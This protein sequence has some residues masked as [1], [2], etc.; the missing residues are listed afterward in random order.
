MKFLYPE[1]KI[2]ALTFS[3]DDAQKFDR[4]LVAIFNKYGMKATFHL[5]SGTL[6]SN[7]EDLFISKEEVNTLYAGHEI[8]CH[9]VEHKNLTLLTRQK[10]LREVEDDRRELER[11]TGKIVQGMSYAYGSYSADVED[12]I[13]TV[14]I[15]YSRTV[16]STG[17]FGVPANFLEWHP[18]CHHGADLT[19][20]GQRFLHTPDWEELPL[21]Y[22]WGH[23]FEFDREQNWD[24]LDKF[25]EL[26]AGKDDIWYATNM[27]ICDYINATRSLEY[28]M[29]GKVVHNP[30]AVTI[31]MTDGDKVI[32][33]AAGETMELA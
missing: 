7:M 5:N 15:K 14:G 18:T 21:L 12:V 28:S 19:E 10:M 2:K 20:I 26:M 30:T 4:Q 6:A 27:E 29:D 1:G 13:R 3:Y 24:K 23:S 33:L 8:A 32:T 17:Y 11:I 22:V 25:C 9:G 31:W 16:G